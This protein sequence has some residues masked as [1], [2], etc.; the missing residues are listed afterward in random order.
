MAARKAAGA[1]H[2]ALRRKNAQADGGV[3]YSKKLINIAAELFRENGY[4]ATTL[5]DIA[6]RAKLDRATVYYY[7]GSKKELFQSSIEGSLDENLAEAEALLA[8]DSLDPRQKVERLMR[9]VMLSY[10]R[11]YPQMFVYIQELM[12]QVRN[13]E[14]KWAKD[15]LRKTRRLETIVR[16]LVVAGID[17]KLIRSDLDPKI[18]TKSLFGMLNWTHRWYRPGS[19]AS[20]HAVADN[21]TRIFFDGVTPRR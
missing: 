16:D 4:E 1:S 13:D 10:D 3:D 15:I 21:F 2:I 19:A 20:A 11:Y 12:H 7:V 18:A 8:D 14:S 9:A 17:A 5:A 6:L